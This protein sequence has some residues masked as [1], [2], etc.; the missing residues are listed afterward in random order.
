M[1][2]TDKDKE[3]FFAKVG[4]LVPGPKGFMCQLWQ[5]SKFK[6]GGHGAFGINGT[7][8]RASRVALA[9]E[10]GDDFDHDLQVNH[11]CPNQPDC[12]NPACLYPGTQQDNMRDK[13]RDGNI[14]Y[15][16]KNGRAKLT[17][18]DIPVIRRRYADGES[19]RAIAKDYGVSQMTISYIVNRKTWKHV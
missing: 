6:H 16:A 14:T 11:H 18:T 12:V 13:I 1:K 17:E 19:Q 2:L 3:R 5:A 10:L 9:I 7:M 15:G 8:H 4:P